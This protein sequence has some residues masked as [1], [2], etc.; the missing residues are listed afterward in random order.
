MMLHVHNFIFFV[1]EC[2]QV[3]KELKL[4]GV[5]DNHCLVPVP[6]PGVIVLGFLGSGYSTRT[7]TPPTTILLV[8][9][10]KWEQEWPTRFQSGNVCG[11]VIV[12]LSADRERWNNAPESS[13]RIE[14]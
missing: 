11:S 9:A 2:D 8:H 3:V 7:P 14:F 13:G 6:V 12:E 1:P 5:G 10:T 4:E